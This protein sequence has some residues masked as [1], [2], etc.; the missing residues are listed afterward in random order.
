M[1]NLGEELSEHEVREMIQEAD[2]DGDGKVNF[3]GGECLGGGPMDFSTF[4]VC[5]HDEA[6]GLRK[7]RFWASNSQKLETFD[8][9]HFISPGE[10][11]LNNKL[12]SRYFLFYQCTGL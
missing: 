4:R 6:K 1:Q 10:L 9:F 11:Q 3:S 8:G 7:S 2:L 5:L 12:C